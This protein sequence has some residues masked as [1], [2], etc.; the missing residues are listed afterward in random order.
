MR[1]II[2]HIFTPR[3][4][5]SVLYYIKDDKY[6]YIRIYMKKM[7]KGVE[8]LGI[9]ATFIRQLVSVR[10]TCQF[11]RQSYRGTEANVKKI[12]EPSQS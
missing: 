9:T 8:K 5:R 4:P 3:L 11:S 2:I 1:A 10:F 7:D 12:N 6:I